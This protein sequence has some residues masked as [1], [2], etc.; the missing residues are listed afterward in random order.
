MYVTESRAALWPCPRTGPCPGSDVLKG[1]PLCLFP[2]CT[3]DLPFP[4]AKA[5]RYR[6]K[7]ENSPKPCGFLV[8][9]NT[10]K[11]LFPLNISLMSQTC[12]IPFRACCT[13]AAAGAPCHAGL[14]EQS[15]AV[16]LPSC[17]EESGATVLSAVYILLKSSPYLPFQMH[18]LLTLESPGPD[19]LWSVR[20]TL[21]WHLNGRSPRPPL[22]VLP[23]LLSAGS[24]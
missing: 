2:T 24:R 20:V 16:P 8:G 3:M 13:S 9:V 17:S 19:A 5:V 15:G 6:L 1:R 18:R 4:A 22:T 21:Q 23:P 11:H 10:E 14:A 7:G 12:S